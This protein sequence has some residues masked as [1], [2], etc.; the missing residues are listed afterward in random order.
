MSSFTTLGKS[1]R[2]GRSLDAFDARDGGPTRTDVGFKVERAL[3]TSTRSIND[4]LPRF[5][6][7]VQQV[8]APDVVDF[9]TAAPRAPR[10]PR[11]R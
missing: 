1:N 9:V 10:P 7:I 4:A 3:P 2:L 11:C 8:T 5:T 6:P